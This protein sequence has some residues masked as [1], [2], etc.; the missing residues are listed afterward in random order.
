MARN[1]V[2][3]RTLR[4]ALAAL[5]ALSA[6][7]SQG[8]ALVLLLL[9]P[10][11]TQADEGTTFVPPAG[12]TFDTFLQQDNPNGNFGTQT[13][14]H[15]QSRN[16][17]RNRRTA[18]EFNLTFGGIPASAAMKVAYLRLFMFDAPTASRTHAAHFITGATNWSGTTV[19]WNNRTT[20][21]PWGT[22]GG[23]FNAMPIDTVNTGTTNNVTLQWTI[24]T[25][26]TTANIPQT[27]FSNPAM[28]RGVIIKDTAE[29]V[30]GG[31]AN[32]RLAQYRTQ[33]AGTPAQ[34]PQ[35]ELRY[36]RDVTLGAPSAGI[37][38]ITWPW[39]FPAGSTAA[40]YDGVLFARKPGTGAIFTFVPADGT[41]YTVGTDLG[42]NE[43]VAIN[44]S[45]F[46]TVSAVEENGPDNVILPGTAYT[47]RAFNHDGTVISGAASA[48][49]PHYSFGVS[50]NVTTATGGGANKNWSYRTGA[51]T[52]SPPALD[53]G[54]IVL[55]GSND[56]RVHTMSAVSGARLYQPGGLIGTTGGAVQS[57]PVLIPA[58]VTSVDCDPI[59][60]GQQPCDVAYASSADGRVYAFDS[61]TGTPLWQS[62]VLGSAIVGTP[63]VQLATFSGGSYPHAFDLVVVGTRNTA[64]TTNN[65]IYG[66]NGNT[67]AIVWSFA[68]GNL[69]IISS[70]GALDYLTNS[71]WFASRAGALGTQPSL[72]KLDTATTNPGGNLLFS[73]MLNALPVANRDIDAAVDFDPHVD[74]LYAVTTG[75]DLVVVD[76]ANPNN[77]FSTN[78]GA[79]SG[80]GFPTILAVAG[81]NDDIYFSTSGGVHKRTF[82]RLTQTFSPGWDTSV[83]TLGGTPST[84]VFA[85]APLPP[86]LY[87]GVSD[88][89]LK[90]LSLSTGAIVLTRDINLGATVGDPSLDVVSA[91]LYVGDSSGRIYSFDIF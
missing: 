47:Y 2:F 68:P 4:A 26:G 6:P 82:N 87:V 43:T 84:P 85:Y 32:A 71:V 23:D 19:T 12:P 34:Y 42:N 31:A 37:S 45:S 69:D 40:N 72:W 76:H 29:D 30:G 54:N 73:V 78:V 75:G 38:E 66:L 59:T 90:K 56:A 64:D 17:N 35:L 15:V 1:T 22:P 44:T 57:R 13:S 14:M 58:M 41:A 8:A 33:N 70:G 67:G 88:G 86:F 20:G 52:L 60:G 48:A 65:A 25:D 51:V 79:F 36:L 24:L 81:S 55:T 89:R 16:L 7:T 11:T 53:P 50:G 3:Q 28:N 49:P 62:P 27:W 61:A 39:T 46:A 21:V 83:A 77:V 18:V 74:Y 91:K 80:M 9:L 63:I 10:H 5:L